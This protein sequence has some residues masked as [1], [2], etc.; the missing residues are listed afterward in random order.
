MRQGGLGERVVLLALL[1]A[2]TSLAFPS[3]GQEA[4]LHFSLPTA[5]V[6]LAAGGQASL[7]L[8]FENVSPY[9]GDDLEVSLVAAEG[10]S[11]DPDGLA[12]KKVPPFTR[13]ALV[14]TLRTSADL[15]LGPREVLL[16]AAYTYC[17]EEICF[18]IV[19]TIA[20]PVDVREAGTAGLPAVPASP[21]VPSM[22]AVL[23]WLPLLGAV[24]LV[25]VGLVLW[26]LRRTTA[27]LYVALALV[28]V[29]GL[30]LGVSRGQH[31]QAQ[32]IASV[33]CTS[34]VGIE[35]ARQQMPHLSAGAQASLASLE[36]EVELTVFYA[37]WCRSCPYAEAM[38]EEMA[39]V[40]A[41]I[42]YRFVNVDVEPELA[43]AHQVIAGGR[44][45]VPA[46][47]RVDTGEILFG[48]EDLE[49]RL[50]R[51]LGVGA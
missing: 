31:K 15:A 4:I 6:A 12:R 42:S 23:S 43:R 28:A 22:G 8:S 21:A 26:R 20:V 35:E 49:A 34:C 7:R 11:L 41:H 48:I 19:E 17:I 25:A 29:G 14:A 46:I 2:V 16:E 5:E 30:A 51:L 3:F 32:G 1:A 27:L 9:E 38:V 37:P 33:L 44:T 10:V 13:D 47:L 39:R 36:R 24:V 45:V 18:Q 50:L 40:T